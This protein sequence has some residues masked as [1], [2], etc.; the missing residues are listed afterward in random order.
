[1]HI[2]RA[3]RGCLAPIDS[4]KPESGDD[5][6]RGIVGLDLSSIS[7]RQPASGGRGNYHSQLPWISKLALRSN[8]RNRPSH[9]C[10]SLLPPAT[11]A[12][13]SH[14]RQPRGLESPLPTNPHPL[15]HDYPEASFFLPSHFCHHLGGSG[16]STSHELTS[17]PPN[18]PSQR[19]LD[20]T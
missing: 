16:H 4:H 14:T 18:V 10:Q 7:P 17:Q 5:M 13:C 8:R 9:T 6:P 15:F 12:H 3:W 19:Q 1:M 20:F 2:P 11:S